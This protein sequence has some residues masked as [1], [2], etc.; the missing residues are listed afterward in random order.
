[1]SI[2]G[3][4]EALLPGRAIRRTNKLVVEIQTWLRAHALASV[5]PAVAAIVFDGIE[6]ILH[7]P[8]ESTSPCDSLTSLALRRGC[9]PEDVNDALEYIIE[10]FS[11]RRIM[12]APLDVFAIQKGRTLAQFLAAM[13]EIWQQLPDRIDRES[14]LRIGHETDPPVM[15]LSSRRRRVLIGQC[16]LWIGSL[17]SLIL[18]VGSWLGTADVV[19]MSTIAVGVLGLTSLIAGLVL[20]FPG[21]AM[22]GV[23]H[24]LLLMFSLPSLAIFGQ[25]VQL[26]QLVTTLSAVISILLAMASTFNRIDMRYIWEKET[27]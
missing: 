2:K 25:R 6:S 19:E 24:V 1:M 4:I 3:G 15:P 11:Y 22:L 27:Y 14:G 26:F 7:I 23:I 8:I 20:D 21:V 17:A 18:C 10:I 9:H 12:E 5:D 16:M 13:T